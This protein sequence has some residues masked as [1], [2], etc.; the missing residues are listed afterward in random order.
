VVINRRT[1]LI[2]ESEVHGTAI[3][4]GCFPTDVWSLSPKSDFCRHTSH[5]R[6]CHP[7]YCR[8]DQYS[9]LIIEHCKRRIDYAVFQSQHNTFLIHFIYFQSWLIN[10]VSHISNEEVEVQNLSYWISKNFFGINGNTD[11][12]L[13]TW[14]EWENAYASVTITVIKYVVTCHEHIALHL[15]E[16]RRELLCLCTRTCTIWHNTAQL[17]AV[18]ARY[19]G[20]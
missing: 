11:K 16:I 2:S 8:V 17:C 14:L 5:T 18:N 9:W 13:Y 12:L 6:F 19:I 1:Q 10:T 20:N 15:L 7:Q 4:F 3:L